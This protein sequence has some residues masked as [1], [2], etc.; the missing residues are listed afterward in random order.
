[1]Y[2]EI[3]AL[4]LATIEIHSGHRKNSV[5]TFG[6]ARFNVGSSTAIGGPS[7]SKD[8]RK[9]PQGPSW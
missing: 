7:D 5:G 8:R 1:M 2:I 4:K 9:M 3:R 6:S